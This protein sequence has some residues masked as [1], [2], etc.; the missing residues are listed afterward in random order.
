MKATLLSYSAS[1]KTAT[2][3]IDSS[4]AETTAPYIN[5]IDTADLVEGARIIVT[6]NYDAGFVVIGVF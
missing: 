2:F 6:G 5:A 1:N 4:T 3:I